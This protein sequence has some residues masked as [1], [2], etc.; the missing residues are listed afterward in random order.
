MT[1]VASRPSEPQLLRLSC[2]SAATGQSR[3]FLVY[4]PSGYHTQV[5]YRW[6]VIVFLHGV[7]ER[8]DGHADL[9]YVLLSGPLGEAWIGHR[10]LPFVMIG[11]QLPIFDMEWQL[12]LRAGVPKPQRLAT[13]PAAPTPERPSQRMLRAPDPSPAVFDVTEAWGDDG[14][15]GGW[16]LCQDEVMAM[17]DTVLGAYRTDPDRVYL[18]GLSYAGTGRGI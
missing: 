12:Q 7:G 5:V 6:P 18:T 2:H 13:A 15:P 17:L 14:F 8:G 10:D 4:L 9:D 16:Q 1:S 3:S 11:P